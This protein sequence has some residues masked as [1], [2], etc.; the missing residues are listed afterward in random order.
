MAK[1]FRSL[2]HLWIYSLLDSAFLGALK[3]P[4]FGGGQD[5]SLYSLV[6]EQSLFDCLLDHAKRSQSIL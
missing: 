4:S 2:L 3:T 6:V 1:T 5:N